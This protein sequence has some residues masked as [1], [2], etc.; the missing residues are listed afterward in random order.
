MK[1]ASNETIV[2]SITHMEN[3][4]FEASDIKNLYL[5]FSN[6]SKKFSLNK[7]DIK[8]RFFKYIKHLYTLLTLE[9]DIIKTDELSR[10]N[11]EISSVRKVI[12]SQPVIF[13]ILQKLINA[14]LNE[15]NT[16]TAFKI[17]KR[18]LCNKMSYGDRTY[19]ECLSKDLNEYKT[20]QDALKSNIK[21]FVLIKSN[22][23][24]FS[25]S[26]LSYLFIFTL[27]F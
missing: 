6:I 14:G 1:I 27:S 8:I 19:L 23:E 15:H 10:L 26:Q 7:K 3:L 20:V 9:Q 13:S 5:T 2:L 18:D 25:F 24:V 22:F 21:K 16:L 12:E 11:R 4:G 17:F